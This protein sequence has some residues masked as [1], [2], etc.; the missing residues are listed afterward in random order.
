MKYTEPVVDLIRRR[1]AIRTYSASPIPPETRR[2]VAEYASSLSKLRS[3]GARFLVIDR[4]SDDSSRVRIGTYGFIL[5]ARSYVVCVCRADR[6]NLIDVGYTFEDLVL[7]LTSLGL[8]TC[9][10]GATFTRGRV[11]DDVQL[12]SG[13]IVPVITPIGYAGRLRGP[14]DVILK[15]TYSRRSR[16]PWKQLFFDGDLRSPLDETKAAPYETPLEMVRLAPSASNRQPWRIIREGGRFHFYLR[17][18]RAY[19]GMYSFDIQLIDIGIAMFHFEQTCLELGL[20]GS[21]SD[22]EPMIGNKPAQ[23]EYIASWSPNPHAG[24]AG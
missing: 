23:L 14:V 2:A 17:H 6:R 9:W 3:T 1:R 12:D 20:P 13:E 24:R 5:G 11:T 18:D 10:V 4:L 7:F 16:R 22:R 8:G 19:A 15:P 21:W